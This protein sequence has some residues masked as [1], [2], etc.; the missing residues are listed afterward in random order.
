VLS[1]RRF[2]GNRF[3]NGRIVQGW[4]VRSKARRSNTDTT[5]LGDSVDCLSGWG[6]S[7]DFNALDNFT[8][9][10]AIFDMTPE[11]SAQGR[12]IQVSFR[13]TDWQLLTG[14]VPP[15]TLNPGPG[16]YVDRVRIGRR[17]LTGP[18]IDLGIDT[19]SQAQDCFTT[20]QNSITPGQ[21]FSPAANDIFG[22]CAFSSAA[23]LGINTPGSPSVVTGD[24]IFV[25][26][27]VDAR[28][29]G[30][31]TLVRWY[32]AIVAGPHVG[33]APAPYTVGANGFFQVQPD[34]ARAPFGGVVSGMWFVDLDDT[35]FRGGDELRY[36]WYAGDAAG[37]RSSS[38]L[39]IG[40]TLPASVAAAEAATGGLLE[41]TF[42]PRITWAPAYLARI[43]SDP[44]GD[45]APT[46]P[47]LAASS[48]A[49]CILYYQH[50]TSNRRTGKINRTSFMFTLDRLGYQGKYD[51]F[52]VQGYGNTNNQLG[53]ASPEW[54]RCGSSARARR[55]RKAPIRSSRPTWGSRA[56]SPTRG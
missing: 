48:Q 36:F 17:V 18:V 55:S 45:L 19:R 23:D 44:N 2:G 14:I 27:I 1:F 16:P 22:T 3:A 11:F 50:V 37:G 12:E 7:L 4:R 52:D 47:E 20:V 42:L 35:Y 46:A 31:I 38:P 33:K 6:H 15:A 30:G 10:T 56:W 54:R 39:G 25:N 40:T 43:A 29:V 53:G 26:N 32:G 5:T 41:V 51:V 24:S 49:S 8:W 28:N 21:H 9:G 34:S 13:T